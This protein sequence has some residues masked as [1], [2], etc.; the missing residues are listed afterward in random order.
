VRLQERRR[1]TLRKSALH[2]I[3]ERI[4]PEL[5]EDVPDPL[6]HGDGDAGPKGAAHPH[7][8][9]GAFEPLDDFEYALN[10]AE[11]MT[12]GDQIERGGLR[13]ADGERR[14][15][16]RNLSEGRALK[17]RLHV[18]IEMDFPDRDGPTRRRSTC[19]TWTA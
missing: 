15:K 19:M 18:E 9:D 3:S 14:R 6:Q 1:K 10:A 5:L 4:E 13:T 8:Y 11:P 12:E 16:P 7:P 17:L 2:D